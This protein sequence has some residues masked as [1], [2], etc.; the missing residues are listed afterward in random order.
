[1]FNYMNPYYGFGGYGFGWGR[2]FGRGRG[3]GRGRGFGWGRGFGYGATLGYCP[4]TGL[5]RGWRWMMPGYYPANLPY[6]N[7]SQPF[8]YPVSTQPQEEQK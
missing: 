2:G 8:N 4:W 3:W 7:Y 1:M 6:Y 5:P